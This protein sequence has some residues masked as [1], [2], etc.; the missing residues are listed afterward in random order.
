MRYAVWFGIVFQALFYS[1]VLFVGVA[2]LVKCYG[3]S[4]ISNQFCL[5][6]AKPVVTLTSVVNVICDFYV[7]ILPLYR[8]SKLNLSFRRKLGLVIV[9]AWGLGYVTPFYSSSLLRS[10]AY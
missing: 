1:A 7:L 2:E 9:F 5:N 8:I 3:L 4:Q 10:E 6:V